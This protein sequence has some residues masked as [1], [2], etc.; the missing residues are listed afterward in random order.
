MY[1]RIL[2]LLASANQNV[3]SADFLEFILVLFVVLFHICVRDQFF[4]V[5]LQIR[6]VSPDKRLT[7]LQEHSQ[8]DPFLSVQSFLAG[9]LGEQ[10]YLAELF[11]DSFTLRALSLCLVLRIGVE[12]RG[13]LIRVSLVI[14]GNL[15][16]G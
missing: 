12:E 1:R 15:L 3:T 8:L 6:N 13:P 2:G 7:F 11:F 10:F 4:G 9:A 14:A 16:I 5:L